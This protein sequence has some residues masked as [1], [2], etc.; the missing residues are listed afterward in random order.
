[1]VSGWST[2]VP[3]YNP[4]D[5]VANIRRLMKGEEQVPMTPWYRGFKGTIEKVEGKGKFI[6][7]GT[8]RKVN[9]TTIEIIE[10]PIRKW[11]DDYKKQLEDWVIGADR[12]KD[13]E[14]EKG[15]KEKSKAKEQF[16]KVSRSMSCPLL[17]LLI[18][19]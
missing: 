18:S 13:K 19:I 16:I 10:L 1:M 14:K 7:T 17:S 8:A 12:E 11:T 15:D 6:C 2:S 5:I 9:S 3:N 4:V